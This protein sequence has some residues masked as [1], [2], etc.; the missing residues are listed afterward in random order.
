[1]KNQTSKFV[2]SLD[3]ELLWGVF[4]KVNHKEKIDYFISTREI[5]PELL[6]LFNINNINV[7]WATVGMLFNG[8]W[9]EWKKNLP[10]SFPEYSNEKLSAY[11]FS[12]KHKYAIDERL[13]FASELINKIINTSGQELATHTYSHYY[14]LEPGQQKKSF[15]DDLKKCIE[16]AKGRGIDLKSL[17]F[18]RNQ[19]NENYLE[20]CK[21]NSITS[22][23]TN[24]DNWYWKNT[25]SDKIQNKI[26]RTMDAYLGLNDKGY[27]LTDI[28]LYENQVSLQ[29]ASRFLRPRSSRLNRLRISRILNEITYAA[30]NCEVYHLW[31]HPHNFGNSPTESLKDL[32]II[33]DHFRYCNDT[34]GMESCSMEQISS[35]LL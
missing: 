7:T 30:K 5:I 8:N 31:W 26:F 12:E 11:N 4:D 17:V 33:L 34:F 10:D 28:Q 18:P 27:K 16:L 23:R 6:N 9:E 22:V 25:Q 24:P 15:E 20:V 3:F 2:I 21:N 29:K 35:V 14:C 19:F 32:Q 1:M 13:C